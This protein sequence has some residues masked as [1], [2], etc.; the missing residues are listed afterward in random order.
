MQQLSFVGDKNSPQNGPQ[1]R[2]E[3]TEN[4]DKPTQNTEVA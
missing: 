2:K 4:I 3:E 1:Q